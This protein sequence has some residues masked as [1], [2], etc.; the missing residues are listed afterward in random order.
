MKNKD[1]MFFIIYRFFSNSALFVPIIV[2]FLKFKLHNSASALSIIGAYSLAVMIFEVPTGVIADAFGTKNTLLIGIL[3]AVSGSLAVGFGN[4]YFVLLIGEILIAISVS[5]R[6]GADSAFLFGISSSSVNVYKR[7]EGL[8]VAARY[9]ALC[10][11]SLA[12][13]F[14]FGID[15]IFPFVVSALLFGV[16]F[17]FAMLIPDIR[18]PHENR[19]G[20]LNLIEFG[21]LLK[22]KELLSVVLLTASVGVFFSLT[23]WLVQPYLQ[24]IKMPE[25]FFGVIYAFSFIL[26][27]IG[28][29][30]SGRIRFTKASN[31][32]QVA[33]LGVAGA[34]IP[35]SLYF[36]RNKFGI[37]FLLLNQFFIGFSYP[38]IFSAIQ[39][40]ATDNFRATILSAES[41]L[42]RL[43]LT[44]MIFVVSFV[45]KSIG[46]YESLLFADVILILLFVSSFTISYKSS[47]LFSKNKY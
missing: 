1:G 22:D 26:S 25:K 35:L 33:A 21:K 11:S 6:S 37:I 41:L 34:F 20:K 9:V 38:V 23:Y 28:A 47:D 31:F 29:F 14:L 17:F 39:K 46:I 13:S 5:L 30:V 7:L 45:I 8:S 18:K 2:V 10:I 43:F 3:F 32:L 4:T 15:K 44:I 36:V 19:Y 24:G 42:Q 40:M 27:A 12:G 16:S